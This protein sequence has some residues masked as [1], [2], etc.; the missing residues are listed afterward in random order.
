MHF[1]MDG[2]VMAERDEPRRLQTES[3]E[4]RIGEAIIEGILRPAQARAAATTSPNLDY[5]QADGNYDQKGG[6]NHNQ[7]NGN[8]NQALSALALLED[9]GREILQIVKVIRE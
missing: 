7:G 2:V 8:Y 1:N 4:Q 5:N 9:L 3:I 6:G